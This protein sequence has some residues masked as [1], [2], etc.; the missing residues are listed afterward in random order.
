MRGLKRWFFDM[1]TE[2]PQDFY[3]LLELANVSENT[4]KNI[5]RHDPFPE[6]GKVE[7]KTDSLTKIRMIYRVK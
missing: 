5:T 3:E 4:V 1:I 6:R 7:T 2:E